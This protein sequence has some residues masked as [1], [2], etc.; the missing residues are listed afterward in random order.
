MSILFVPEFAW[1]FFY[2]SDIFI[3]CK[4]NTLQVSDQTER[5]RQ[6]SETGVSLD[7]ASLCWV[8]T[9]LYRNHTFDNHSV[10]VPVSALP[11]PL[12]S[13]LQFVIFELHKNDLEMKMKLISVSWLNPVVCSFLFFILNEDLLIFLRLPRRQSSLSAVSVSIFTFCTQ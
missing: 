9:D 7:I 8:C 1:I 12:T 4:W 11:F 5:E 13:K 2:R 10:H 6:E 3:F